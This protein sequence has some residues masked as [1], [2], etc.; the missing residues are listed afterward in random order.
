MLVLSAALLAAPAGVML[1]RFGTRCESSLQG[2]SS[3]AK[4]DDWCGAEPTD[5]DYCRCRACNMCS[6]FPADGSG[7]AAAAVTPA[8]I[9]AAVVPTT[10]RPECVGPPEPQ[11]EDFCSPFKG[12]HCSSCR[13]ATCAW[14]LAYQPHDAELGPPTT[15]LRFEECTW[16]HGMKMREPEQ[17]EYCS[18]VSEYGRAHCEL[19]ISKWQLGKTLIT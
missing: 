9:A 16:V 12:D 4:C 19:H 15:M 17:S 18:G 3:H 6:A 7:S 10:V 11:C 5:C 8:M 13:C 14:C 2:D 1:E